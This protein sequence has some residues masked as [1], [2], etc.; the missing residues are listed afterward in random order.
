MK[1]TDQSCNFDLQIT[2]QVWIWPKNKFI[3][4]RYMIEELYMKYFDDPSL[5]TNV[6]KNEDPF[7]DPVEDIYIG[8]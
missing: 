2:N 8:W 5:L 7:W 1:S 3:N 6:S 4:R